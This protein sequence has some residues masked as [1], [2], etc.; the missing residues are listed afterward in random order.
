M[1]SEHY[2]LDIILY[3]IRLWQ[4]FTHANC[5]YRW[6]HCDLALDPT[7]PLYQ[8]LYHLFC[9]QSIFQFCL[10]IWEKLWDVSLSKA[11]LLCLTFLFLLTLLRNKILLCVLCIHAYNVYIQLSIDG[12]LGWLPTA[13]VSS[14]M[15][16]MLYRCHYRKLT[17]LPQIILC[18]GGEWPHQLI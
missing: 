6:V 9:I 12:P 2:E 11:G 15:I 1:S 14:S 5:P 13:I 16:S 7:S 8:V 10:H 17:S 3:P 18:F 4:L